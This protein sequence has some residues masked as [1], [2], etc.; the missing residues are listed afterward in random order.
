MNNLRIDAVATTLVGLMAGGADVTGTVARGAKEWRIDWSGVKGDPTSG[1]DGMAIALV[2]VAAEDERAAYVRDRVDA[3]SVSVLADLG[4][5][6]D[7]T[8][9]QR[10]VEGGMTMASATTAYDELRHARKAARE[11]AMAEWAET[12]T[13][14]AYAAATEYY[15]GCKRASFR[16][17]GTDHVFTLS[18]VL[19]KASTDRVRSGFIR[20][21]GRTKN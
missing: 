14:K 21:F 13:G 8:T 9:W 11:A 18:A 5:S 6:G 12:A 19:G 10:M 15:A 20:T 3:A 17:P 4:L 2:I 16:M 1:R 7:M